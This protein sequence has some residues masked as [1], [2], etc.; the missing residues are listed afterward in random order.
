[1]APY[2]PGMYCACCGVN[3]LFRGEVLYY[4]A[5]CNGDEVATALPACYGADLGVLHYRHHVSGC[6]AKSF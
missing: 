6:C 5:A 2:V 1:M 4:F 3:W